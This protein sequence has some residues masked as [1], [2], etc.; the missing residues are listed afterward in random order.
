[1]VLLKTEKCYPVE[2]REGN[3][4]RGEEASF[5][6][7]PSCVRPQ[8]FSLAR[9]LVCSIRVK[10]VERF[11]LWLKISVSDV[12]V[13]L[14]LLQ[15]SEELKLAKES[16]KPSSEAEKQEEGEQAKDQTET[17]ATANPEEEGE[18]DDGEET[19]A[20][21]SKSSEAELKELRASLK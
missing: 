9:P 17:K 5:S 12:W 1:M 7:V 2:A 16:P 4:Q 8:N 6:F 19:A 14:Y 15:L 20:S 13:L 11:S 21:S 3:T 18:I 10:A